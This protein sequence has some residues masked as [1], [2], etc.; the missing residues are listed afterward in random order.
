[1]KKLSETLTKLGIA[2]SFPIEIRDTNGNVTY[3]EDSDDYCCRYEY[4][5]LS[6]D[7]DQTTQDG[8]TVRVPSV[9]ILR[10]TQCQQELIPAA[11]AKRISKA[12]A[13]AN[14]QLS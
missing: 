7:Y 10:C 4:E 3:H 8:T 2:F 1:M 14:E 6:V 9:E 11:S 13:E 5:V 12:V